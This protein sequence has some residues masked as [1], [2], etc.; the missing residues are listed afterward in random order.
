MCVLLVGFFSFPF[1]I[2]VFG[3]C[4][5]GRSLMVKYCDLDG[6]KMDINNN[7]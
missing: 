1:V 5:D 3:N 4:C 2:I 7:I 6:N